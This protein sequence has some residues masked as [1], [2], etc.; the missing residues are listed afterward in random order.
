VHERAYQVPYV[1]G[2]SGV[3]LN[4]VWNADNTEGMGTQGNIN[5]AD[6]T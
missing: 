6:L 1:E 5:I 2:K 4:N 3:F